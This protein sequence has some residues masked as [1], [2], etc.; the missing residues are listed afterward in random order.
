MSKLDKLIKMIDKKSTIEHSAYFDAKWYAK[1]YGIESN[2]SA[3]HYL[4]YGY[5]HGF[6]PSVYFSTREYIANNPDVKMN[7]LLHYELYG[8]YEHRLGVRE[9]NESVGKFIELEQVKKEIDEADVVSFDIFDTLVVRPFVSD[10]DIYKYIELKNNLDHFAFYRVEAE[11]KAREKYKRDPDLEE[12]YEQMP[13]RYSE[14]KGFELE[15]H[16]DMVFPNS[17]ILDIY[18][19][20]IDNNKKMICISDMYLS[21]SF[22]KKLL[23]KCGFNQIDEVYCSSKSE[24]TKGNGKLYEYVLNLY[25]NKK[26]V[27]FGDNLNS[28]VKIARDK[29][30]KAFAINKNI[31]ILCTKFDFLKDCKEKNINLSFNLGVM[32]NSYYGLSDRNK[33]FLFGFLLG[34]PLAISYVDYLCKIAKKNG[35]EH[36]LFV[37]RDGYVLK[38]IYDKYYKSEY[39]FSSGYAYVTRSCMLSSTLDYSGEE[40]YLKKL[41]R[42]AKDSGIDINIDDNLYDEFEKKKNELVCWSKRNYKNLKRHLEKECGNYKRIMAIDLNTKH[43][44]SLKSLYHILGGKEYLGMFNIVF[45]HDCSYPY[46]TFCDGVVGAELM[47]IASISEILLSSPEDSIVGIDNNIEPIYEKDE[48]KNNYSDIMDGIMHFVDIMM[49]FNNRKCLMGFKDWEE[50]CGSYILRSDDSEA[51][52]VR[53]EKSSI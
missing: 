35:I 12:I 48:S 46:E 40:R 11:K 15:T 30:I 37:A 31:E 28:D 43:F 39:G 51:R 47:D 36:L 25:L 27:H 19:Y 21:S 32:A 9:I 1:R 10:E 8:K 53:H 4:K 16:Y 41:L 17:Q 29:G 23:D 18:N 3:E 50:L 45:G 42:L 13:Y 2:E 34:G 52:I 33:D 20:C 5:R 49:S 24:M 7:P 6:D 22:E 38:K 14:M 26:I 44:T